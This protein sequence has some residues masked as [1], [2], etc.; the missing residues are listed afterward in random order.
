MA[1]NLMDYLPDYYD[2]VYEME[3]I[4]HAQGGVLD[5]AESEQ[6]RLLLNQFV[7]QTDA[8]GIAVFEDQV[9]IKPASGDTLQMRQNKVLMRLLP[10][11]P[12]T[13]RYMRELFVTLKIPATIRVDYP[14]RDAIVE[15]KNAEITS[16][17]IDNVKYLLNIYLPANMVY[18][19][20]V[21]LNEV[22]ITNNIK[23]GA[24]IWSRADVTVQANLSQ[25]KN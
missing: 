21:A 6:L 3:A 12:I 4:M 11:R 16:K 7:T 25:I 14:K 2:G 5:R 24:G 22:Q 10:P 20:R 13:I 9:G 17:Q 15:A 8:K 1:N 23:I 19:I 18:E